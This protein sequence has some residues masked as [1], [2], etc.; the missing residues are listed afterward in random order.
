MVN[1]YNC[2]KPQFSEEM[3]KVTSLPNDEN[4]SKNC[5]L[6]FENTFVIALISHFWSTVKASTITLI[7]SVYL[8]R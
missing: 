5:A 1:D 7:S 2:S 4:I 6:S 3:K 8:E